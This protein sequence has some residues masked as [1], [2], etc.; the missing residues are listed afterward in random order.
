VAPGGQDVDRQRGFIE[1]YHEENLQRDGSQG[2]ITT[3]ADQHDSLACENAI[4]M[5]ASQFGENAAQ[6]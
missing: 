6:E 1:S 5:H 3:K 4:L 2:V